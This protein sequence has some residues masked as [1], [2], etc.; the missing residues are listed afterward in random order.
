LVTV[1]RGTP[2][3]RTCS[4]TFS[5]VL[6]VLVLQRRRDQRERNKRRRLGI[7]AKLAREAEAKRYKDAGGSDE[8]VRDC[9]CLISSLHCIPALTL[10][11]QDENH[12]P[13]PLFDDF[14][15]ERNSKW[16][17]K[18]LKPKGGRQSDATLLCP[19][20]FTAL[21][22]GAL[23]CCSLVCVVSCCLAIAHRLLGR[24]T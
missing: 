13:D 10:V 3:K 21:T 15:D 9:V 20:C 16:V 18:H 1:T 11:Q 4:S 19:C 7:E 24:C 17:D 5:L 23:V 22:F 8:E 2:K 6:T 14:E 12:D